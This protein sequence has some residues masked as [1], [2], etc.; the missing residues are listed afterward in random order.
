MT[1][2]FQNQ[3]KTQF[4]IGKNAFFMVNIAKMCYIIEN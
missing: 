3:V 2:Q 1:L 4:P